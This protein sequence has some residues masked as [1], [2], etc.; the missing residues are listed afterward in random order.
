MILGTEWVI[1]ATGCDPEALSD[2]S[3]L[4][5]VFNRLIADLDL[6]VLQEILWHQFAPP[7]GISGLAL[8]SESHLACHTFPE[9]GGATFNL[10]CCRSRKSWPWEQVLAEM[11]GATEVR[12]RVLER[13]I[14][15]PSNFS[16]SGTIG[17]D[18][19]I[20]G[21]EIEPQNA[22]LKFVGHKLWR[23]GI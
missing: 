14:S 20:S 5:A 13:T 11:L 3:C 12:V 7:G 9:F 19:P 17:D 10:Y 22:K 23:T 4:R 6:N 15:C 1:D 8:L 18:S 21:D 2:L 16:S